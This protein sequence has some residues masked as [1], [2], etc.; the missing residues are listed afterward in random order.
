[1][2]PN[3]T[4]SGNAGTITP[5]GFAALVSNLSAGA[6][7]N[8]RL[9]EE[10][11]WNDRD[12]FCRGALEALRAQEQSRGL[13]F[14]VALLVA[15]DLLEPLLCEESLRVE[16]AA[17]IVRVAMQID[18]M[19]E[20]GLARHL[21]E[22]VT[23]GT[24]PLLAANASRLLDILARVSD[25][26]RIL[27][28]LAR[29][30]H[31]TDAGLRSKAALIMGRSNRSATWAQSRMGDADPRL[32][33]N[34]IEGLWGV[35]TEEARD[36]MLAS[37]HDT[38][39]RV[40]GNALC[41][42][43]AMGE[44]LSLAETIK[45]AAHPEAIFRATAAWVMGETRDS[46]FRDPV[47]QLL[48]DPHPMVRSRALRSVAQI[49]AA[50]A[51]AVTGQPWRLSS[52]MLETMSAASADGPKQTR[53][54]Q[55]S[56]GAAGAAPAALRP[57]HFVLSEDGQPVLNYRVTVRPSPPPMSVVFLFPRGGEAQEPPWVTG[58]LACLAGKRL[59]D[60]W[61]Y[62]PWMPAGG[63]AETA[64]A[65]HANDGISFTPNQEALTDAFRRLSPRADCA[66]MWQALWRALRAESNLAR[67][68]RHVIVFAAEKVRGVAGPGLVATVGAA[69][70][71]VQVIS[72]VHNPAL[73]DLRNKTRISY[74]Y[75][76]ASEQIIARIEEAYLNLNARFEISYQT[77]SQEAR[78]LK[79]RI[80]C[81]SGWGETS[82]GIPPPA[83]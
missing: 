34:A 58:A 10:L 48:R 80:Q 56:V 23:A 59:S 49:K 6:T 83:T 71:L 54:L 12:L 18:P 13:R 25:G 74:T 24:R 7:G 30:L 67:G 35:E 40:V 82:V 22:G 60:S 32:R 69:L 45:L 4:S 64:P 43:Y 20:I 78:E 81:P 77:L 27:P 2:P 29:L 51:Q 36:L 75:A 26:T 79:I 15:N 62:L 61:A 55:V 39:N 42:L 3:A 31:S 47:A 52:L 72:S 53:R 37:L 14:L 38:N 44:S 68:K 50:L 8:Q 63:A 11:L 28:S 9:I 70:G 21:A 66:D 5:A 41:G 65:S 46:R 73:E 19:A 1:M 33:A 76:A 16:Q 57:I 17:A